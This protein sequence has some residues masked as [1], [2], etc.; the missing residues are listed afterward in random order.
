[1]I[2]LKHS[3][4]ESVIV[5]ATISVV[6][7]NSVPSNSSA[8]PDSPT[9]PNVV[10]IMADDLAYGDLSCYGSNMIKT[11]VLDKLASEGSPQ[12]AGKQLSIP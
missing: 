8:S 6:L 7:M 2:K 5:L 11:P 9:H 4:H 3:V 1:M 10:L 12:G